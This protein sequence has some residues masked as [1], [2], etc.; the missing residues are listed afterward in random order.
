M[1]LSVT[2]PTTTTLID[3]PPPTKLL[4]TTITSTT[5]TT[6]PITTTTLRESTYQVASVSES[7]D[8]WDSMCTCECEGPCNW[9]QRGMHEGGLQFHPNTWTSYVAAGKPYGLEGY[10]AHAYDA[11]REQQIIVAIRV[12]D[13]VKGSSDPYLNA[14]GWNAWPTCRHHVGV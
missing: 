3:R 11:T 9:G 1:V 2:N 4:T 14:Q 7:T 8:V 13:G 5:T 12:R 10:P 6:I